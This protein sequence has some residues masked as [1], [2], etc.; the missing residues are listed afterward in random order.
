MQKFLRVKNIIDLFILQQPVG[1]NSR[2]G[3]IKILSHKGGPGRN[4]IADLFFV[5]LCQLCDHRSVHAVQV[6]LQLGIFKNHGLQGRISRPFTDAEQRGIDAGAAVEPG[7]GGIAHR[8][9]KVIMAMPF[10]QLM[11]HTRVRMNGINNALNASG[12]NRSRI[13]NPVSHG[14]AGT[15]LYGN[16]VFLHKLHQLQTK[17]H[18]IP[19]DIRPGDIL[20]MTPGTDP[21]LQTLADNTEIM[22]HSLASGHLQLQENMIIGAA[23]QNSRLL[24]ADFLHQLKILLTGADPAGNLRKRISPLHAL[25]HCIPVLFTVQEKLAGTNHAVRTSQLVQIIIDCDDL[26]CA[27]WGPGLLPVPEGGIRDPY[28]SGHIMRHDSVVKRN[29]RYFRIRKHIPENIGLLHVV[30]YVHMLLDLQ[31]I[32]F[33]VHGNRAI[34]EHLIISHLSFP[35]SN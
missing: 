7:C 4:L 34:L 35:F 25:I 28:F 13:V 19:I 2:S 8:L 27:V 32:V 14:I 22:I 1:V 6:S 26:L 3:H 17:R 11:G 21:L 5:I 9:V 20:H 29:L 16:F 30:Q 10:N 33:L 24:H 18:H 12:N 23:Y 31:Q 15:H